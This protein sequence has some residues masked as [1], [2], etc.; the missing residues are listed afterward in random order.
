MNLKELL[1]PASPTEYDSLDELYF[2]WYLDDLVTNG[3]VKSY[4]RSKS[5]VLLEGRKLPLRVMLKTKVS[6]QLKQ[7]LLHSSVTYTPDFIIIW[8]S[9]E[10][11]VTR[12]DRQDGFENKTAMFLAR[13]IDE[14]LVSIIDIKP[15][16]TFQTKYNTSYTFSV[17]QAILFATQGVMVEKVQ[18]KSLFKSSF[19]P[20]R[21]LRTDA[22]RADRKIHWATKTYQ[23]YAINN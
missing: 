6:I 7:K 1:L 14:E 17:K 12:Y 13:E 8:S 2:M 23:E 11:L 3:I 5:I 20:T 4:H 9:D 15:S 16:T 10:K 18:V 22:N 21:F 19:T